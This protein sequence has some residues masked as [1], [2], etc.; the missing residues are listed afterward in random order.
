MKVQ[1]LMVPV[2][3]FPKISDS[4]TFYEALAALETAQERFLVGKAEQ[5]ILLV[6]NKD[7]RIVGKISPIDLFV[8]L[9]TNYSRVNAEETVNRFGLSYVWKSMQKDYNLWENPFK[10][11]CRKASDVQIKNFLKTPTEGQSV[12]T[13]DT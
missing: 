1:D 4:A 13:Q 12:R 5:R 2:D 11:L 3:K 8:G 6:E 10:D 7:G 9:E